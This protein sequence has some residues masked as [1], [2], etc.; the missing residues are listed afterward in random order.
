[1][2]VPAGIQVCACSR[3]TVCVLFVAHVCDGAIVGTL[4][5]CACWRPRVCA[6]ALAEQCWLWCI[7]DA[8]CACTRITV[9]VLFVTHVCDSAIVGTLRVCAFWHPGV[10]AWALATHCMY[11]CSVRFF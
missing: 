8:L 11:M 4:C 2:C 9:C 3:I 10:C 7:R 6:C 1:M 5:A